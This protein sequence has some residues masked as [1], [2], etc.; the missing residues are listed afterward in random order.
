MVQFDVTLPL[1]NEKLNFLPS[2]FLSQV[3]PFDGKTA[4]YGFGGFAVWPERTH[5]ETMLNSFRL[6]PKWNTAFAENIYFSS[7]PVR[8]QEHIAILQEIEAALK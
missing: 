7:A 4:Q 5:K 3:V 2:R 6:E 8:T 1:V